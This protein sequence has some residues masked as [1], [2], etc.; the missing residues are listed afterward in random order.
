MHPVIRSITLNTG[1]SLEVFRPDDPEDFNVEVRALIGPSD[2]DGE[3]SFDITVCTPLSLIA[4]LELRDHAFI[5]RRLLV[6]NW[7][8]K[9]V[10]E[11][12][13]NRVTTITG[14]SWEEVANKLCEFAAWEFEN[15]APRNEAVQSTR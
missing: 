15:Y 1:D 9:L 2:Q 3:E 13:R 7:A 4:E 8:P 14:D 12:L 10:E 6:S 5:R 11:A